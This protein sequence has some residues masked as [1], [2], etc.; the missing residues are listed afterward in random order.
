MKYKRFKLTL[1]KSFGG[2]EISAVGY[3]FGNGTPSTY[4]QGGT[5]AGEITYPIFRNLFNYLNTKNFEG[6]IT[7]VPI[8]NPLSWTQRLYFYTAG[9]FSMYDGKDW[10]RAYPGKKD[11]TTAQRSAHMGF[12]EAKKHEFVIDLHTSRWSKPFLIIG[13]KKYLPLARDIGISHTYLIDLEKEFSRKKYK[14]LSSAV[15]E[16]GVEGFTLECG[17]H[18]SMGMKIFD[19]CTEVILNTLSLRGHIK[20]QSKLKS[21]VYYTD[22]KT[23]TAPHT[24]FV[25]Y[26]YNFWDPVE[27][28]KT[29]CKLYPSDDLDKIIEIKANE[30]CIVAKHQPTY[31]A[32]V[33]DQVIQTIPQNSIH[34]LSAI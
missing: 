23:Y 9:K 20:H 5:H 31:I 6:T 19:Y 11:G 28:G 10:N 26:M 34:K 25:E 2:S 16:A 27:K 4:I 15:N 24:G 13:N 18:D 30:N 8:S 7:L 29:L 21:G 22:L 33:G 12:T 14:P 17:S 32:L 1:G 3:K